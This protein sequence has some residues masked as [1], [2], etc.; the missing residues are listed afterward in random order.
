MLSDADQLEGWE[1]VGPATNGLEQYD[2]TA[3]DD[4]ATTDQADL[5]TNPFL[6]LEQ[7]QDL[8]GQFP[9]SPA[10]PPL[11]SGLTPF[12]AAILALDLEMDLDDHGWSVEQEEEAQS[13]ASELDI[14]QD[15]PASWLGVEVSLK[16]IG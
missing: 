13:D 16:A 11:A 9:E 14:D 10:S 1:D 4:P 12:G 3:D 2:L 5:Q 8:Q 7:N 6:P 15:L